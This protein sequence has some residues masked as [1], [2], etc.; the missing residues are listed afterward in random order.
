[1]ME[2]VFIPFSKQELLQAKFPLAVWSLNAQPSP[3]IDACQCFESSNAAPPGQRQHG[4]KA[5]DHF[6]R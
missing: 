2:D 6:K 1:M 5:R 4:Q 3:G